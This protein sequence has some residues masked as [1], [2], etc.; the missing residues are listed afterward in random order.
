MAGAPPP[1]SP[2]D[3]RAQARQAKYAAKAQRRQWKAQARAQKY[4]YRSYWRGFR[5]PSFVGPLVLLGI[6]IVA[7]LITTGRMDAAQFWG[8]Y[9]HWW[10]VLL[11]GLGV[12]LLAE[13]F[14]DWGSPGAGH[15]SAGG[16]VWVVILLVC[17]GWMSRYGHLVGP[18]AWQFGNN[19]DNFWNWMG[20]EHDNNV[21]IDQAI[22]AAKPSISITNPRGDVTISASEDGQLHLRAHEMVYRNSRKEAEKIF[23][24]IRPKVDV[25]GSGAVITVPQKS[26][27]AVDLTIQI[28]AASYATV[29]ADN[30]DVTIDGVNGGAA[31][32]DH[33]GDVRLAAIGGEAI[34][35]MSRGDFSAH[36]VQGRV[37]VD[38]HGD[39][40]TLSAVQGSASVDGE[41]YGD[42]HMEQV[43]GSV[44]FHSSM[45]TFDIPHLLG[46]LTL[47]NADLSINKAAGPLQIT[48]K[49]KDIDLTQIAGDADIQN[50][51]GDIDLVA[52]HPLGNLQISNNTG[53]VI[54]T[55]PQNAGFT[56]TGSTST[57]EAIHTDFPLKTTTAGG[58]QTLSGTVGNGTVH[59]ELKTEHGNL[60]IRKGVAATLSLSA[61]VP[62]SPPAPPQ[63]VRHFHVPPG[64]NPAVKEQ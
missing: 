33:H 59:L 23:G 13:Y 36:N 21:Q 34:G 43:G 9:A 19:N 14:I 45:T 54:V 38:G 52:A 11:I 15:R 61:P 26:G 48:A 51:N 44:H 37:L 12:L 8:W 17:F 1:Y 29:M 27:A 58:H 20:P 55:M 31:V 30:G 35:H 64:E 49:S 22:R 32:T 5:R 7:L 56:V 57:D 42:I 39:D 10:P 18:F 2:Y 63:A 50:R 53:D 40:V 6:G 41:F 47:D 25:S 16:L 46:S 62:P 28:P 24:D 4:Y 60:E 3:A